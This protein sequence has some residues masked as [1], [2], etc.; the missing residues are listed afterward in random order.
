[1]NS[2]IL[3]QMIIVRQ[4]FSKTKSKF[5]NKENNLPSP[6]KVDLKFG[7]L[8]DIIAMLRTASFT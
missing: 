3:S 1:M 8:F 4:F 5:N 6:N 2:L 7:I